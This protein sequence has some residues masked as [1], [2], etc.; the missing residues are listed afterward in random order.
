MP[1][2]YRVPPLGP[3][4]PPHRAAPAARELR[5]GPRPAAILVTHGMGQQIPFQTLDDVA[6]GLRRI[7]PGRRSGARGPA[8][9]ARTV[10]HG[11]DR[12]S[13]LEL[14]LQIDAQGTTREVHIYEA[15]WA[16]LTEGRV[17]LRDVVRFLVASGLDGIRSGWKPFRRWLFGQYVEFPAPV[18]TVVYLGAALAVVLG[19]VAL[20]AMVVAVAA[21]RAPVASPPAWLDASLFSDLTTVLN[22]LVAT[23]VAFGLTLWLSSTPLARWLR[24][25]TRALSV[26]LLVAAIWATVLSA[27]AACVVVAFHL[28]QPAGGALFELVGLGGAT[29]AFNRAVDVALAASVGA[30]AVW[31]LGRWFRTFAARLW[32]SVRDDLTGGWLTTLVLLV[33]AAAALSIT[34]VVG[35]L[36]AG[37]L[38]GTGAARVAVHGLA[39]PLVVVAAWVVRRFLVQYVGDVVAYVQSQ[40]LDRFY[41]LRQRIK[42]VVWRTARAVYATDAYADVILVG[43]SLGSVVLYDA[44]NRLLLE[45]A[46]VPGAPVVAARTRLLL[47]FGSPLDKT[48]FLF[49]A[50]GTGSEAREALAAS[51]QPLISDPAR[52]PA[53]VNLYSRWDI[54]SGPLDYYDLPHH[55]NPNP[56]VNVADPGASTLLAAHVEYWRHDTLF[57]TIWRHLS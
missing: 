40:S 29:G 46:Q 6:E 17:T 50:Q 35:W 47:T 16:P 27:A 31:Y 51:V 20:N 38:A 36:A 33:A 5:T 1:A 2:E 24:L 9:I 12:L 22:A 57:E 43:H 14:T 37:A 19:L 21:A 44:L 15:Y 11:D 55:A 34:G 26:A 32:S 48:A 4:R 52:R 10:I 49:G 39:W 30:V 41:E 45:E 18:R 13:R 28:L 23:Y 7:D 3:L 54:I 8:P 53:W 42:D 56:V 25:T